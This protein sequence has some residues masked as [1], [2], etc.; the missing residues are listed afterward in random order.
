MKTLIINSYR[1]TPEQKISPFIEMVQKFSSYQVITDVE[2]FS[3]VQFI[4]YDA[5]ILSGSADLITR[6]AYSKS[7]VE[8][9]RYNTIPC[10]GICY[11]HQVLAK[12]FGARIFS[13][14]KRIQGQETIRIIKQDDLFKDLPP[15]LLP[16]KIILNMLT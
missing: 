14:L 12:A 10:L 3:H 7:Y 8:F 5:F 1:V 13:K 2:L 15:S 16:A 4:D 6:G 11:G 9:L